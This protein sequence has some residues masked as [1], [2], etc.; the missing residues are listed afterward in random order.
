MKVESTL[1]SVENL[2]KD[3]GSTPVLSDIHLEVGQGELVVIIGRSGCG[4]TTLL[5][6]LNGLEAFSSGS[7]RVGSVCADGN[8]TPEVARTLRSSFGM[9][10]QSFNL[11][12]HLRL[13]DNITKA[14]RVVLGLSQEAAEK[15]AMELLRKVGLENLAHRYPCQLSGGQQQRAA[16]ARALAMSPKVMLYDEPTSA[17]DPWLVDEVFQ[18]MKELHREG[19]TQIVVTHEMRFA[20]AIADKMVFMN[21]GKILESAT[22]ERLFEAPAHR[23]TE[24]FLQRLATA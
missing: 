17:L 23:E 22:P 16:I 12:P 2:S 18:V 1:I 9:V 20:R 21:E 8:S 5:R 13:I 10:F 11:F 6:C 24:I 3:Y 14:P 4:K 7:I 19:M 15:T